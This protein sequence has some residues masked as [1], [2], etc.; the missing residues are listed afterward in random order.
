MAHVSGSSVDI[1]RQV[2]EY[3]REHKSSTL[4]GG[5]FISYLYYPCQSNTALEYFLTLARDTTKRTAEF[6]E[7]VSTKV[8]KEAWANP[9]HSIFCQSVLHMLEFIKRYRDHEN[10]LVYNDRRQ[11]QSS[12]DRHNI[13][14]LLGYVFSHLDHLILKNFARSQSI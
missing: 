9:D 12:K 6:L 13:A 8:F 5:T 7:G 14:R 2:E 1:D 3:I 11:Q 4:V 10:K